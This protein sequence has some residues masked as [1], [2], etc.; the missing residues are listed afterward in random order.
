[1]TSIEWLSEKLKEAFERKYMY[2][3]I[4]EQA[5]EM[6]KQEIIDAHINGHNAP[7]STIK[8]FDAEQY[9]QETFKKELTSQ[10]PGINV[11]DVKP[12]NPQLLCEACFKEN[13]S[14]NCIWLIKFYRWI[15][16]TLNV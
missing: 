12:S 4:I 15:K 8:N 6:H 9:Y 14:G 11:N 7:S 2:G 13:C 5:K 1:M 3:D 16:K 10:L